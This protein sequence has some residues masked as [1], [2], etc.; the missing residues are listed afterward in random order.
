MLYIIVAVPSLKPTSSLSNPA[1]KASRRA[2]ARPEANDASVKSTQVTANAGRVHA[3]AHFT[4]ADFQ[5]TESKVLAITNKGFEALA[6]AHS[7]LVQV[8][9]SSGKISI[10]VK[11][12]TGTRIVFEPDAKDCFNNAIHRPTLSKD[13]S[14]LELFRSN[15]KTGLTEY[16]QIKLADR[17][18]R[19]DVLATSDKHD[20]LDVYK[21]PK[22]G[23]VLAYKYLDHADLRDKWKALDDKF[24]RSNKF[25]NLPET[26]ALPTNIGS[27]VLKLQGADARK[28]S[29][30]LLRPIG[31]ELQGTV[32]M[33]HGGPHGHFTNAIPPDAEIML[34][35]GYSVLCVNHSG[36]DGHG[37][38]LR[39][40]IHGNFK[41]ASDDL[42]AATKDAQNR[43]LIGSK[44]LLYGHSFG[45]YVAA[46][47]AELSPNLFGKLI[48]SSPTILYPDIEANHGMTHTAIAAALK[49]YAGDASKLDASEIKIPVLLFYG[50]KDTYGYKPGLAA[51]NVMRLTEEAQSIRV[52]VDPDAGH[53]GPRPGNPG[54]QRRQELIS[55]FLE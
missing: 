7:P 35:K 30:V 29:A 43:G 37:K 20:I 10:Q 53:A 12:S 23:K 40:A 14:G 22:T 49:N 36:S 6:V 45:T 31:G 51:L 9:D 8:L 34:A 39:Q 11:T 19:I 46:K 17:Q 26:K 1:A 13:G 48:L 50:S 18:P 54:Y 42:I 27:T 44:P 33:A 38:E 52:S 16:V 28:L 32:V 5:I 4:E 47:A 2:P 24:A 41:V 21:D 55:Q 25:R 15:P 3:S